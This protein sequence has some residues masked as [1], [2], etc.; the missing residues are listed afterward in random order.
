L[1]GVS[2]ALVVL[3]QHS[4]PAETNA[5][6]RKEVLTNYDDA[7]N[8]A[9]QEGKPIFV[10]FTTQTQP[11]EL[12]QIRSQGL[13]NDYLVVVA[14]RN[15]EDGR[16]IFAQFNWQAGDGL[17]V[18][19]RNRQWQCARYERKLSSDELARVANACRNAVGNAVVDVLAS[20]VAAY[21]PP[22]QVQFGQPPQV[23]QPVMP[24]GGYQ[25]FQPMQFQP[26]PMFGGFGGC[27]SGH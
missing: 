18:I 4:L 12:Q 22:A 17:S 9:G 8:R 15:T 10:L 6:N 2:L 19:E 26:M 23:V 21:P 3:L 11:A 5:L 24:N 13:L 20:N 27:T 1:Y 25:Q 16:K 14:D 7:Y